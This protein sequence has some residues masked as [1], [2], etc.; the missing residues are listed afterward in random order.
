MNEQEKQ[1]IIKLNERLLEKGQYA[2]LGRRIWGGVID[3]FILGMISIPFVF[4]LEFFFPDQDMVMH[5]FE[6]IVGWIY[7]IY[8]MS[9]LKQATLGG[10]FAGVRFARLNALPITV[11]IAIKMIVITWVVHIVIWML[12]KVVFGLA[13][14]EELGLSASYFVIMLVICALPY[15]FTKRKQLLID[16][17]LGIVAVQ[18]DKLGTI[19]EKLA[20]YDDEEIVLLRRED[21]V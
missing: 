14:A 5:Y 19:K 12:N 7:L 17:L 11:L 16:L 18:D 2:G 20:L 21:E 10:Y 4:I 6:L 3:V 8:Y 13:T 15:F 9:S 1:D